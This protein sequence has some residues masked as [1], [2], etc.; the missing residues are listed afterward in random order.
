MQVDFHGPA[1]RIEGLLDER[2]DATFAALVCHP[3]PLFGGTMH[4]HATYRLAKA[5]R[6]LGGVALRFNYRGIGRSAGTY[7][8]GQ[9]EA[10]DARAALGFLAREKP[11]LSRVACGFSFGAFMALLAG[12]DDPGVVAFLIAG[13]ALRSPDP[14]LARDTGVLR[15]IPLP[16][17]LAQADHDEYGSLPEVE[18]ALAGAVGPRRLSVVKGTTHLFAENLLG[19][20]RAA[21]D[22]LGWALKTGETP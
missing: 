15:S 12:R 20:E 16:I 1:G 10:D 21:A 14:D 7:G 2:P 22:L 11:G 19:L 5:V 8:F 4:N 9:G 3:H 17:A 18:K 13:L 6:E